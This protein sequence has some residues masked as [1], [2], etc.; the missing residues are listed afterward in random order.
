MAFKNTVVKVCNEASKYVTKRS[1]EILT[2]LGITGLLSSTV[3]AVRSTPEAMRRIGK[4]KRELQ[5]A[6]LSKTETVK[7]AWK[8]YIPAAVTAMIS[9]G[10]I[11]GG[12]TINYK[13]NMALTAAYAL[14]ETAFKDYKEKVEETLAKKDVE[15]IKDA[16]AQGNIEKNPLNEDEVIITKNGNHLCYDITSGRYFRS[17]I[18]KIKQVI[19]ELNERLHQE[20]FISQNELF[21]ELGLEPVGGGYE[22]GW[23]A[24]DGIIRVD[25]SSQI[26]ANGEPCLTINYRISPLHNYRH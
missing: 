6:E 18:N 9:T 3:L 10:C 8:C 20:Q 16:V 12:S 25:Y 19:N 7:A 1:P 14:S 23:D 2:G 11:V 17:D 4:R 26:A 22:L 15:K 13:R 21:T 5:V 24:T